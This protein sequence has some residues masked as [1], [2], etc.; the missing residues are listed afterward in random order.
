MD[1]NIK[2]WIQE[3]YTDANKLVNVD[4]VKANIDWNS[5]AALEFLGPSGMSS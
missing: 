1:T 5:A 3:A 4:G 2:G